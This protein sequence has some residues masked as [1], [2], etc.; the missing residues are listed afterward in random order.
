MSSTINI[1]N[2]SVAYLIL[3]LSA[4]CYGA[5]NAFKNPAPEP[6][7]VQK[8]KRILFGPAYFL[9]H[10]GVVHPEDAGFDWSALT[11][12]PNPFNNSAVK[13]GA[14]LSNANHAIIAEGLD[15]FYENAPTTQKEDTLAKWVP[16]QLRQPDHS[17][18]AL[19]WGAF[20]TKIHTI[21]VKRVDAYLTNNNSHPDQI[22]QESNGAYEDSSSMLSDPIL[23]PMILSG[24]VQGVFGLEFMV[25]RGGLQTLLP[26][27]VLGVNNIF[28][29]HV[30]RWQRRL[31]KL[32]THHT[33]A[34]DE[35]NAA[36]AGMYIYTLNWCC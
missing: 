15:W 33:K 28:N 27:S 9:E 22:A 2:N 17:T 12:S 18:F 24:F 6:S 7:L 3:L 11:A 25:E 31:N 16:S 35:A 32:K 26:W 1:H 10:F 4:P 23:R 20:M 30:H 29:L 5:T 34:I 14:L 13:K 8:H 36:W 21:L 19:A